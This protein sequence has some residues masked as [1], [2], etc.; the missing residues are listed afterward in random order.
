MGNLSNKKYTLEDIIKY[1]GNDEEFKILNEKL[2]KPFEHKLIYE[3]QEKTK[4]KYM[5][6][7]KNLKYEGRGIFYSD[8]TYDGY[9]KDGKKNGYF[10]VYKNNSKELTYEG[11][12]KDDIYNG[13]GILYGEGGKKLFNGNFEN[14]IYNGIGIEYFQ[15]EKLRRKMLFEK[16]EP[17]KE[18][19]GVLYYENNIIYKGLLKNFKPENGKNITIYDN[20]RNISYIG[21]FT[22]FKYNGKGILYYDKSNQIYFDGTFDMGLFINGILYDPEGNKIYEGEFTNNQPKDCKNINLYELNGNLKFAGDL[23]DGKY[24]GFG[25]LYKESKLIYEGNFK[26]GLYDGNG[27]LYIDEDC[28]YEG[29]FKKGKYDGHGKITKEKYLYFEGEFFQGK[30]HGKGIIYY[31]NKQKYFEGNFENDERKGEGI[32]YYDNSSKKNESIYTNTKSCK[33][34]YYSP[35]NELLYDG[36]IINEIPCND[37]NFKI[38]N[39]CTYKIYIGEIKDDTYNITNGEYYPNYYMS[40]KLKKDFNFKIPFL[41]FEACCGKTTLINRFIHGNFLKETYPTIGL[42]FHNYIFEKCDKKFKGFLYDINGQE[43]SRETTKMF[44]KGSNIAIFVLNIYK[45]IEL[46][47]NYIEQI[48]S[49]LDKD[50]QMVYFVGNKIVYPPNNMNVETNRNKIRDLIKNNKINKYFEVDAKTGEGFDILI[51]NINFDIIKQSNKYISN[52][53]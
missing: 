41:S 27:I 35:D 1:N 7:M 38:Y 19:L 39:D 31:P 6:K 43:L 16:G 13:K 44:C 33:G 3:D 52:N 50:S 28:K 48:K 46:D 22:D 26:D 14:G 29:L 17:L 4:L 45:N 25:K 9:F 12:Y 24:S 34:K 40:E 53:N 21:D 42:D 36:D 49:I 2:D 11:F 5:G 10:R 15:K 8:Y 37:G 20:R 47:E 23:S 30:K 18:C 32:Q 51:K